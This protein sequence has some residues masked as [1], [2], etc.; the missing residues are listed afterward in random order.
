MDAKKVNDPAQLNQIVKNVFCKQPVRLKESEGVFPASIV[1]FDGVHLHIAH[2]R[3]EAPSRILFLNHKDYWMLLECRVVERPAAH[4]ELLKPVTLHLKRQIRREARVDVQGDAIKLQHFLPESLL[5][6]TLAADNKQ[7]DALLQV[8][9]GELKKTYQLI[10]ITLLRSKR[11]DHRMRLLN[12]VHLPIFAPNRF[13]KSQWLPGYV[14]FDDYEKLLSYDSFKASLKSEITIPLFFG[15]MLLWGCVTVLA[16]QEMNMK[17]M[18]N[19]LSVVNDLHGEFV[20]H[21]FLPVNEELCPVTDISKSG[22]GFTH[23]KNANLSRYCIPGEEAYFQLHFPDQ[24]GVYFK[25]VIR[26]SRVVGQQYRIGLE[27]KDLTAPQHETIDKYLK[28]L[29][30][31]SSS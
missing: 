19:I 25:G 30:R 12:K 23:P 14:S 2:K 10:A 26:N 27:F 5:L 3:P 17:D 6:D 24:E 4:Q 20:N 11:M 21:R 9:E 15:D 1:S 29:S 18:Q 16:E 8:Y 22:L 31:S 13:V 7:R 28:M